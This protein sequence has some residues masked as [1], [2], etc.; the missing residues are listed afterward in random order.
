MKELVVFDGA[1]LHLFFLSPPKNHEIFRTFAAQKL[2]NNE[3]RFRQN[4]QSR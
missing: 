2:E 1:K 4:H 3:I